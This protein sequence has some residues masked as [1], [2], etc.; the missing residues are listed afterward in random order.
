MGGQWQNGN[1]A[2]GGF[3][4]AH[5]LKQFH[6]KYVSKEE[7]DKKVKDG[8]FDSWIS[9]IKFKN[10]PHLNPELPVVS[11]WMTT[12]PANTSS[13]VLERNPYSI[14]VDTDGNQLPYID[15]IVMTVAESVEV[16]NLRAIA[17]EY[18]FQAR[19]IDLGKLPTF[20]D[21]QTKGG[22]KVYMDPADYGADMDIRFNISYNKDPE[23]RKW[24]WTTDFRRALSLGTDRE[25]LNETFWLGTG[26][27]GSCAPVETNKYYP[28]AEFRSLWSTYDVKK[29][30]EMLDKIGLDKKDAEGYRLRTDGKG[31]LTLE[32]QTI[33]QQFMPFTKMGEMIREQW[34]KIGIDLT[35]KEVERSLSY[36][37]SV[38]DEQMLSSW[39]NDGTEAFFTTPNNMFPYLES[40]LASQGAAAAKWFNSG[41]KKGEAPPQ[42][43]QEMMAMWTKGVAAS[44]EERVRLGKEIWKITIDEQYTICVVGQGAG[45]MGVRIANVKL[46]NIPSREVNSAP[47]KTYA[48]SRPQTFYWK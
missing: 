6:P 21:N 5:Y 38:T 35:I 11:P 2:L 33:G 36:T 25:Q 22:Y 31:R 32:L 40:F 39:S 17:G 42:R 18:D 27:P 19:H 9:L 12:S 15:K 24:F 16:V 46:G 29:A 20:L 23:I 44:E 34:K 30:N 8:K 14:W 48:I 28:G 1:S 10:S 4:P 45:I 37:R 3:A 13:W 41:G 43:M 7:L 47:A 26:T